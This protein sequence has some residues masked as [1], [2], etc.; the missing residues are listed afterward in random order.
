MND[1]YP[2]IN[3]ANY[4]FSYVIGKN[5]S[6][7]ILGQINKWSTDV[8]SQ[9]VTIVGQAKRTANGYNKLKK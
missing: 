9:R 7:S 6:E 5:I 3:N 1:N 8:F 2:I 4:K